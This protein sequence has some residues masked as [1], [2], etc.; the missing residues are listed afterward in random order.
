MSLTASKSCSVILRV[1]GSDSRSSK[2][3]LFC[4][5]VCV[6]VQKRPKIS[7][8]IVCQG[9]REREREIVLV[10]VRMTE[11]VSLS[12]S[13]SLYTQDCVPVNSVHKREKERGKERERERELVCVSVQEGVTQLC[14]TL[15]LSLSDCVRECVYMCEHT[16]AYGDCISNHQIVASFLELL[17]H[18]SISV[19]VLT[20]GQ[21]KVHEA[22]GEV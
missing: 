9:G 21:F 7:S 10:C 20:D 4:V 3:L 5:C 2:D 17:L 14:E 11:C 15:S 8:E 22:Q 1:S 19:E 12:L 18:F 16:P 6:F 13:L